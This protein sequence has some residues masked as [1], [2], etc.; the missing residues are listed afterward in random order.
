MASTSG[1]F[2]VVHYFDAEKNELMFV[3]FWVNG[4]EVLMP[5]S[6]LVYGLKDGKDIQAVIPSDTSEENNLVN[7]NEVLEAIGRLQEE[8]TLAVANRKAVEA[9]RKKAQEESKKKSLDD[10][11]KIE[12]VEQIEPVT[13]TGELNVSD[14]VPETKKL[15]KEQ[16]AENV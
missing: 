13:D 15:N 6:E 10:V 7:M 8:T 1:E 4:H 14:K 11:E 16:E 5:L 12:D 2:S 3:R 9:A